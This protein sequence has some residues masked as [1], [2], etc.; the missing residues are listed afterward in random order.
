LQENLA[1]A[2]ALT[3]AELYGSHES[4]LRRYAVRLSSDP[5]RA[6]DLVS[7]TFMRAMAHLG[8]L[9][10]LNAYQR[11][12]WLYRVLKNRFIDEQRASQR[13]AKLLQ[14]MAWVN[15]LASPADLAREL[16]T[17]IPERY[18]GLLYK[19]YTL[20][21]TSEEIGQ[22]LGV[23]AATIRSR[24]RLAIQWVRSHYSKFA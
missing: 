19:H 8:L 24:L 7:E 11:R 22:Q 6:N 20:G 14:Q 12:A 2:A 16:L 15:M 1:P 5:D 23:P 18:R 10:R 4:E 17:E 21:M 9:G 13:E 3:V